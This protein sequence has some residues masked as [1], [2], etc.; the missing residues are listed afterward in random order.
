MVGCDCEG[1]S[2]QTAVHDAAG[3]CAAG[4]H[5]CHLPD[6]NAWWSGQ[7]SNKN[8]YLI[9]SEVAFCN[10]CSN[11]V[12][13]DGSEICGPNGP[14]CAAWSAFFVGPAEDD[15]VC[16]TSWPTGLSNGNVSRSVWDGSSMNDCLAHDGWFIDT[17]GSVVQV[18]GT[19]CCQ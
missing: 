5:V 1:T 19:L 10:G 3:L 8:R 15:V 4:W 16:G 13:G 7:A 12:L 9:A 11:D 6:W 17:T 18:S 14:A 2:C